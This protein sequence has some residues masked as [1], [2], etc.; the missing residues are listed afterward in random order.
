[1]TTDAETF[2]ALAGEEFVRLGFS[3]A[4]DPSQTQGRYSDSSADYECSRGLGLS[5]GFENDSGN[6]LVFFGRRW[7]LDQGPA[8]LSNYYAKLA[9]RF[10]IDIPL[11]YPLTRGERRA[12]ELATILADLKRTL[13]EVTKRVTLDDLIYVERE[14]FGAETIARARFGAEFGRFIQVSNFNRDGASAGRI[15]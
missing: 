14:R 15:P 8:H 7:S 2:H 10:G 6:A 3:L 13:P 9:K 12:K 5:V 1:M 4:N 11:F